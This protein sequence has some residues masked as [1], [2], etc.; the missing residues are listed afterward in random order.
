MERLK[1][2]AHSTG[3]L[4]HRRTAYYVALFATLLCLGCGQRAENRATIGGEVRLDGKP[5][6]HGLIQFLPMAGV[7]GSITSGEIVQGRY[8]I[9]A[10][11]GPAVGWNRVEI[12][13]AGKGGGMFS[14][15][16][17]KPG[18]SAETVAPRYNSQSTLKFE[19]KP[20]ENTADFDVTTK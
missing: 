8:K 17:P 20:G 15:P 1:C 19:V 18:A 4:H 6:E 9:P 16:N 12:T 3:L 7:E 5:L 14:H 13:A 11:T 10:K 2:Q